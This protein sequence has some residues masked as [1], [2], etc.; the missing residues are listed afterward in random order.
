MTIIEHLEELRRVLIVSA[1]ATGALSL[2]AAIFYRQILSLLLSPLTSAG[3]KVVFT[4]PT[5]AFMTIVKVCLFSGFLM[6]LPIILWQVWSFLAP[7]LE[8]TE[9]RYF[10]LF[11][12]GSFVLFVG[13][14]LF[15]FFGVYR[16]GLAFLLRFGG[17]YLV[18]MLTIGKYISFTIYFLIPFGIIFELP[19]ISYLLA[20]LELIS[21]KFL[22][23]K[24]KY[25]FLVIVILAAAITPTPDAFT[26]LL[27]AGPMYLLYEIS[28]FIVRLTEKAM[29]RQKEKASSALNPR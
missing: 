3:Y 16:Y 13:G 27:M 11:V 5:E 26:C 19:L 22:A 18:P 6:A 15:G 9:K 14:V 21:S 29:A 20:R 17:D 1:V 7:A 10:V 12:F 8:E 23:S 25:A 28:V 24:R 4:A 2:V